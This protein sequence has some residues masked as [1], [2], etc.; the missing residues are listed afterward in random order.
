MSETNRWEASVLLE[1]CLFVWIPLIYLEKILNNFARFIF[2]TSKKNDIG[3]TKEPAIRLYIYVPSQIQLHIRH[4]AY[5][6]SNGTSN[7]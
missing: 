2:L 1:M 7:M 6:L 4:W 5:H 3:I